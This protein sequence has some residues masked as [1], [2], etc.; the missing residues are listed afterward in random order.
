MKKITSIAMLAML[1]INFADAQSVQKTHQQNPW[2]L[3]YEGAITKNVKGKVNIQPVTYKIKDIPIAAN[4][5][6]PPNFDD[7]QKYPAMS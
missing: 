4:V 5:Y 3:V 6:T 1:V 2:T 7:T